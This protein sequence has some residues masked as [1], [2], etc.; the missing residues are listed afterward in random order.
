MPVSITIHGD[1]AKQTLAE[2]F[3]LSAGLGCA[4]Q[5]ARGVEMPTASEAAKAAEAEQP[6]A[7]PAPQPERRRDRPPKTPVQEEAEKVADEIDA[8]AAADEAPAES[9]AP[10]VE[11]TAEPPAPAAVDE[12]TVRA[13]VVEFLQK[14]DQDTLLGLA[15]FKKH[16][17]EKL[18][19]VPKENHPALVAD[20]RA[21]IEGLAGGKTVNDLRGAYGLAAK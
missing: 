11:T 2:L 17:G 21:A 12:A 3:G 7:E 1:N 4:R 20:L 10:V 8:K 6:A 16:G 14:T 19:Q 15:I 18:S 5:E 13:T 9:P